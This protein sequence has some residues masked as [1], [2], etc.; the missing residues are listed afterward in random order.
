MTR[1]PPASPRSLG[2]VEWFRLGDYGHAAAAADALEEIGARRLRTHISWADFRTV[3]G[4]AWYDWL[5]PMLG[6]RFDLLPCIHYTPPD[7]TADGRTSSPPLDLK[8]LADFVDVIITRYGK[9]FSTLEL[10]NEPNNLLDWNWRLDPDWRQFCTMLGAAAY[11]AQQRGKR[12]V[13][14]ASSP[15]DLNWLKLM[16]ERGLLQVVNAVGIHGFPGTWESE[17][18]GLWPGWANLIAQVR[19]VVT[20]FNAELEIWVTETGYSTWRYDSSCQLRA[21][22]GAFDA[23]VD[24][25]YW[26]GLRDI[27]EA[28]AVQE[29]S[30]FDER[31]YHFGVDRS[32]G[33]PKLLG[34]LLREGG[35]E[36]VRLIASETALPAPAYVHTKPLLIT[37]GAGFIGANLASRLAAEGE[38]VLLL[39]SLARTGV[40]QNVEWLR[41]LYPKQISFALA[42]IRDRSAVTES[43][44]DAA[45]VFH[46]AAQV[47][48]T[49]S[50]DDPE[51][52]HS[53]NVT[54]TFYILEAL[55]RRGGGVPIIFASTNKVYGNLEQVALTL[56]DGAWM[57]RDAGLREHGLSEAFPLSF[58]T[59]YGC[60]KGAADQYVLDYAHSFGVPACIFRMS[61][62]YGPRQLGTEDQG[63]VAHFMLLA[64]QGKPITLFGDGHQV[65]DILFAPDA[66]AAYVSAWKRIGSLS[67]RAFNLGG[68]TSNAVS[69]LQLIEHLEVLL[70]RRIGIRFDDWRQ[71]DQRYFVADARA[72]R[73][74]LRLSDPTPWRQGTAQLLHEIANRYG[75]SLPSNSHHDGMLT[76]E[77]IA[78]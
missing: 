66:V 64:V 29:G 70:G 47:A 60:S 56:E 62:I 54:G 72:A 3:N 5:L 1:S 25:I 39:D 12:V 38:Q 76:I 45:G 51:D 18:A 69:L 30:H 8:A 59:P 4:A 46:L 73:Q 37:G 15:T 57:P 36:A 13:L 21:F 6:S 31:H 32:N 10:W 55:R 52:D 20:P 49:T 26:Y 2:F 28:V 50:L 27:P 67:G 78:G 41:R 68:G 42:D 65:R 71:H 9:T 43:I 16:G 61:C 48:V 35:V 40:E 34:R 74:V 22:L 14:P 58:A 75:V 53:I 17:Y 24:Q 7:L 77:S 63:W 33:Q 44:G 19:E 11:W 23:P